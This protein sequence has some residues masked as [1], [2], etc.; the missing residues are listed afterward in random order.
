M[1]IIGPLVASEIERTEDF[2]TPVGYCCWSEKEFYLGHIPLKSTVYVLLFKDA[3]IYHY[4]LPVLH[5]QSLSKDY[6]C[7]RDLCGSSCDMP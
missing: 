1:R 4:T 3:I 2:Y 7:A 5:T 6:T